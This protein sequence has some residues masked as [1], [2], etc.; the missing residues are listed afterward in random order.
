[1]EGDMYLGIQLFV[2]KGNTIL[3]KVSFMSA[4]TSE[5]LKKEALSA[6]SLEEPT[7]P[8]PDISSIS[9]LLKTFLR[10]SEVLKPIP[11]C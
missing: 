4:P 6:A 10:I 5:V 1:V 9:A 8:P 11:I 3:G 2:V 7:L